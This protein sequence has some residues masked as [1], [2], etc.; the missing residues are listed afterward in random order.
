LA[1]GAMIRDRTRAGVSGY[2]AQYVLDGM[3]ERYV[4]WREECSTVWLAYQRWCCA[5]RP[6]RDLAYAAYLAALEREAQAA[7]AYAAQLE[8]VRRHWT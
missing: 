2:R 4:A 7:V 3:I 6:K 1:G 8:L 5:E